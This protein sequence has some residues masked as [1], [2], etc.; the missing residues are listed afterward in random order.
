VDLAP[1]NDPVAVQLAQ[2]RATVEAL[3]ATVER[4][5][6]IAPMVDLK[7]A[8]QHMG[9]STRTLRR[10]VEAETVPYRRFG[11]TLRFPLAALGPAR[12]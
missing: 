6:A 2:L 9:V 8:A 1:N 3:T 12:P 10:M 11:R 7:T 5:A 4:L